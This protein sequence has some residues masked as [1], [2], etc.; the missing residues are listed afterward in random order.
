LDPE[1]VRRMADLGIQQDEPAVGDEAAERQEGEFAT[2]GVV[3]GARGKELDAIEANLLQILQT[4]DIPLT[5]QG[6]PRLRIPVRCS[7]VSVVLRGEDGGDLLTLTIGPE[8]RKLAACRICSAWLT[9]MRWGCT[10]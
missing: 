3:A 6:F 4:V 7:R 2:Q 5:R 9:S 8:R 1:L 10:L